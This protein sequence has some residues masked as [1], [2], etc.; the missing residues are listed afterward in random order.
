LGLPSFPQLVIGIVNTSWQFI[1]YQITRCFP[2]LQEFSERLLSAGNSEDL[3]VE[4]AK[5]IGRIGGI[6][7]AILL[8]ES[9][10]KFTPPVV[11]GMMPNGKETK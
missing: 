1:C 5:Q 11:R 4:S 9:L 3:R 2:C 10:G 6:A 8:I 7:I